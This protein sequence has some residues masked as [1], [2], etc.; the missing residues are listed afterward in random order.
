MVPNMKL[1]FNCP[2]D[3]LYE[4]QRWNK[5]KVPF[6]E[7]TFLANPNVREMQRCARETE[8]GSRDACAYSDH[9]TTRVQGAR[10]VGAH[11]WYGRSQVPEPLRSGRVRVTVTPRGIAPD[12]VANWTNSS[13][14]ALAYGTRLTEVKAAVLRVNPEARVIE[15]ANDDLRRLCR[16]LGSRARNAEF[17]RL[18]RYL[19]TESSRYCPQEDSTCTW[20]NRAQLHCVRGSSGGPRGVL[21]AAE[22]TRL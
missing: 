7:H 15:I 21:G 10:D 14:V 13:H 17:N 2:M 22:S 19:T 12:T 4:T 11:S 1:P 20:S 18:I 8:T 6:R 9:T 16:T 5:K 3:S